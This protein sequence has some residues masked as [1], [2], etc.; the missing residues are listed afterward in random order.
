[1]MPRRREWQRWATAWCWRRQVDQASTCSPEGNARQTTPHRRRRT[2]GT[3]RG[4]NSATARR[5][6]WA[7]AAASAPPGR[8][9][10]DGR[11][12]DVRCDA[13][14]GWLEGQRCRRLLQLPPF[15]RLG[16]GLHGRH[17]G[18]LLREVGAHDGEQGLCE[19]GERHVALPARPTA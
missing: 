11:S 12:P 4:I 5:V 15:G 14:W 18:E 2:S 16:C 3:V 1:M 9:A 6:W 13:W 7:R 8:G 19:E 10:G 17:G